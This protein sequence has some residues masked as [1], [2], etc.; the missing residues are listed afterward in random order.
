MRTRPDNNL[1]KNLVVKFRDQKDID[2]E[3]IRE[4]RTIDELEGVG[5]GRARS[6]RG[7]LR[8]GYFT[9]ENDAQV[10]R[11]SEVRK[12]RCR[13]DGEFQYPLG[14]FLSLVLHRDVQD[15]RQ[16]CELGSG[17]NANMAMV[18]PLGKCDRA[19]R[20]ASSS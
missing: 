19:T 12:V 17:R 18:R 4:L 9:F 1:L 7:S 10:R 5:A 16:G 13:V 2:E 15:V 20:R 8:I 14:I 3:A 6:A 11:E